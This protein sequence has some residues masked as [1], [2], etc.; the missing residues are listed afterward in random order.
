M[1]FFD[2]HKAIDTDTHVTEPG[3]TWTSRI[4]SKWG[5]DVPH[6]QRINGMDTWIIGGEFAGGPGYTTM[7]GFD[8]TIPECRKTFEE[9]PPASY[10]SS[11]RLKRMDREGI[12]AEVLYP[13]TGG[14]GSQAFLRLKDPALQ[15]ECVRAYN[16]FLLD[17]CSADRSRLVPVMAAPFW[18]VDAWVGEIERCAKLGFNAILTCNQPQDWDQPLLCDKHWDRV[19]AAAQDHDMSVSFHI[20]GGDLSSLMADHAG[21]GTKANFARI[22]STIF[23]DNSKCIADL[24]FGGVCHR[25]PK[26]KM[27]SVESAA[28]W[29]TSALEAMDWQWR[30]GGVQGEHPEYDLLPSEYFERQIYGCFWFEEKGIQSAI[31][32]YPD[33]IMWET[34]Y[35]H[36]TSMAPGPQVPADHPR[37][38]VDRALDG[39][40][41]E[42]VG[43][44]LHDT[45]AEIYK[46]N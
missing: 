26:L 44:V 33:N 16:D 21:C 34:D 15:I 1:S 27:V 7:A 2:D 28:G 20:G 5:E 8:G 29:L 6:I 32:T 13:N 36:P 43:K 9:F 10:D 30:N 4:A 23:I 41:D 24:I 25:F 40:P 37:V 39:L 19:W 42:L 11:E 38:Y 17:W 18:N 12:H 14:F 35:P 31:R 3:D 46:L 22:S 45:A